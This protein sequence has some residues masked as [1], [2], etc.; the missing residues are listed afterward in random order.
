MTLVEDPQT[1]AGRPTKRR[2]YGSLISWLL[3]A[4]F[5]ASIAYTA[6]TSVIGLADPGFTLSTPMTWVFYAVCFAVAVLARRPA[7][8]AQWVVSVIVA[9][10]LAISVFVYPAMFTPRQQTTVGWLENDA[11]VGLLSA[12][13]VLGVLRLRGITLAPR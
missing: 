13:L 9:G 2:T 4:A 3:I 6:Y 10:L 12:A 7:A 1:A 8:V 5:T 11:Y